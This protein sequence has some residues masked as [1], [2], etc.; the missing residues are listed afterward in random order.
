MITN[1]FIPRSLFARE[2]R[3]GE[4]SQYV[5]YVQCTEYS[6][7]RSI[8]SGKIHAKYPAPHAAETLQYIG[9]FAKPCHLIHWFTS[10]FDSLAVF[11]GAEAFPDAA[12]FARYNSIGGHR[13]DLCHN[14]TLATRILQMAELLF[15][16][17]SKTEMLKIISCPL[18]DSW[19]L[20]GKLLYK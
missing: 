19:T 2:D 16:W 3:E 20:R 5:H 15:V 14:M 11:L 12:K 8:P 18:L 13:T 6:E 4:A 10:R 7:G 9:I 17:N 1:N